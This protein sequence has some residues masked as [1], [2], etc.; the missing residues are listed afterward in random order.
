MRKKHNKYD[1][2][3][4]YG[5]V[6]TSNGEEYWFDKED[7]DKI[8]DYYWRKDPHG[9]LRSQI[10]DTET[11]KYKYSKSLFSR[12]KFQKLEVRLEYKYGKYL[13]IPIHKADFSLSLEEYQKTWWLSQTKEE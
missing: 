5:I 10:F 1:L 11:K 7:Y 9:Y 4:E 3:G 8:K 12:C 2:S 13:L 6:Y